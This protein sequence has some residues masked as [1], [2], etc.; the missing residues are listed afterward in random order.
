MVNLTP[1]SGKK[2]AYIAISTDLEPN[3]REKSLEHIRVL[4]PYTSLRDI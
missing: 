1:R 2:I 3:N 4:L